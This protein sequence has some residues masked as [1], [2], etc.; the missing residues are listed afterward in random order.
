MERLILAAVCLVLLAAACAPKY[1]RPYE[2]LSRAD[3]MAIR[4]DSLQREATQSSKT[5]SQSWKMLSGLILMLLA[6]GATSAL[7]N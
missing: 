6:A 5:S 1:V 2:P 7:L 4:A 3:T